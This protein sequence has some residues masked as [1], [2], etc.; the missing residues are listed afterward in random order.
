MCDKCIKK[1]HTLLSPRLNTCQIRSTRFCGYYSNFVHVK[2]DR[3]LSK[4]CTETVLH[5]SNFLRHQLTNEL[6]DVG[7]L[8]GDRD[9]HQRHNDF[10]VC[11]NYKPKVITVWGHFRL[12]KLK[13]QPRHTSTVV[14]S[15]NIEHVGYMT[16]RPGS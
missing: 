5:P 10:F 8:G 9:V 3:T 2:F 14:I 12:P 11:L 16:P 4:K 15:I 1:S 6:T 7:K 13:I